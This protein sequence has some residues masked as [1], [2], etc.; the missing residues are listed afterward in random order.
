MQR[1][2]LSILW[3]SLTAAAGIVL[4][5][6]SARA[7]TALDRYQRIKPAVPVQP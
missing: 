5:A 7:Q 3:H 4:L 6:G 1:S 2:S